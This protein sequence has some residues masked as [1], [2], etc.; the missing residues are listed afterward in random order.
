MFFIN[1][2][3]NKGFNLIELL[4]TVSIVGVLSIVGI[5]SYQSQ[6]YKAKTAE[7]RY[8]LSYVYTAESSFYDNWRTYHEN[9]MLVGAVPSG[10]YSYDIGFKNGAVISE[11]DG[12]LEKYPLQDKGILNIAECTNFH[13]ICK[14]NCLTKTEQAVRAKAT[15]P[16][17]YFNDDGG[18]SGA[19]CSV[20]SATLIKDTTSLKGLDDTKASDTEFT[21]A[22]VGKLKSDDVWTIDHNKQINHPKDGTQ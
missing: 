10:I 21:A 20:T 5:K 13:Q 17:D 12:I 7:A 16:V 9:L 14:G 11:T 19:T 22:A 8:A 6:T 18:V 3:Q 4:T 15:L 2:F 1:F